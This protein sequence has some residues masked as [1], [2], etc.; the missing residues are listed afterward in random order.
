M[1]FIR[2]ILPYFS[3]S[4]NTIVYFALNCNLKGTHSDLIDFKVLESDIKHPIKKPLHF[5]HFK[6]LQR[7]SFLPT[8]KAGILPY[9]YKNKTSALHTKHQIHTSPLPRS[10][11]AKRTILLFPFLAVHMAVT[12]FQPHNEVS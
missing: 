2:H 7:F 9:S 8:V 3:F 11:P 12:R 6:G 4:R 5:P 10:N 1:K